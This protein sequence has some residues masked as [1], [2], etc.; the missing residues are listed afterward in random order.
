MSEISGF[1]FR[2]AEKEKYSQMYGVVQFN[3]KLHT[4]LL[5]LFAG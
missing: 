5:L 4:A 2:I 3:A 1:F